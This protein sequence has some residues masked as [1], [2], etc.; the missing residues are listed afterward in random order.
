M[1]TQK[2]LTAT[3]AKG[4][5]PL[6]MEILGIVWDMGQA[7]SR[8]VFEKMRDRR[9]LGQSTV[10]TV[11]RRLSGRGILHRDV[12]GGVYVYRP[13]IGR[14]ELGMQ[15]IDNVVNLIFRGSVEP[16]LEHLSKRK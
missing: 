7:T 15:M 13:A 8:D 12:A 2:P 10:L 5:G 9:R 16:A 14:E 1:E 11:L 4:L 3:L 6:E